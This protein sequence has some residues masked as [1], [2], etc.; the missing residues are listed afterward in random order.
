MF[1]PQL[2]GMRFQVLFTPVSRCF[3][4]FPHGTRSLSVIREYLAL[5]DGPPRFRRGFPCPTV[6]R[7]LATKSIALRLRG[8]HPLRRT[9]PGPSPEQSIFYFA[10]EI[11]L[12][13]PGPTTP[14]QQRLYAYTDSVWALPR[15][16]A[17]TEG[18]SV[19]FLSWRYLDVSVPSVGS[20]EAVTT[21]DG[22]RVSPFGHLR[23]IARLPANRS[24]SQAPT[25]FIAS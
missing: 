15:S 18:V 19:D 11:Q 17:A 8:S 5:E 3:S 9:F 22:R 12:Q 16:L 24:L 23:I 1:L 20:A 7:F 10:L 6:L 14:N 2:V 13:P 21:H 25:P 4:P